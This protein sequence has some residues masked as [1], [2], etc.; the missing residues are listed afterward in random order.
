MIYHLLDQA[1]AAGQ[2]GSIT[3]VDVSPSYDPWKDESIWNIDYSKPIECELR[4]PEFVLKK[5]EQLTDV[6]FSNHI[7]AHAALLVSRQLFECLQSFRLPA[8]QHYHTV[9]IDQYQQSHPYVLI[10]FYEAQDD[11][12]DFTN[13]RF[14][15]IIP[16]DG[17]SQLQERSLLSLDSFK[18]VSALFEEEEIGIQI[19]EPHLQHGIDL[20]L[21]RMQ[22]LP[23]PMLFSERL[24]DTLQKA[25]F[26][27]LATI[28]LHAYSEAIK[29]DLMKM[30]WV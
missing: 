12:I 10:Y 13:T 16:T 4:V 19:L 3:Q 11:Q 22:Y 6:V 7:Q 26:T 8:Y 25:D 15:L 27:G 18:K 9:I 24:V 28:P 21:L 20:D 2:T 5:G 17:A 29:A 14:Y 30:N 23:L 1:A